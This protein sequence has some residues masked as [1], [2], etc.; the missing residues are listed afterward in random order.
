MPTE[1]QRRKWKQ[2]YYNK[3]KDYVKKYNGTKVTCEI[4]GSVVQ[5]SYKKVHQRNKKCIK[6]QTDNEESKNQTKEPEQ[7]K[8]ESKQ[9][10]EE[11]KQ[12]KESDQTSKPK[13]IEFKLDNQME[14]CKIFTVCIKC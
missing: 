4:C 7:V 2:N 6:H 8:E 3:H 12:V 14:D 11:P 5:R 1:E 10:I 13:T 9:D